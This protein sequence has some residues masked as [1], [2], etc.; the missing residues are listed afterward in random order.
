MGHEEKRLTNCGERCLG[1]GIAIQRLATWGDDPVKEIWDVRS[2]PVSTAITPPSIVNKSSDISGTVGWVGVI[3]ARKDLFSGITMK[4][5][6]VHGALLSVLRKAAVPWGSILT[7]GAVGER[8]D[9]Y[10]Q[11]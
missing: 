7:P 2:P 6:N 1:K 4:E 5:T 3:Q 10:R 8:L 11:R 9:T